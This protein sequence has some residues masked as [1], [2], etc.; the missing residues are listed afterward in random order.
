MSGANV[1]MSCFLAPA[2]VQSSDDQCTVCA[3]LAMESSSGTL[4]T[5][6]RHVVVETLRIFSF[7]SNV[8]PWSRLDVVG[9]VD[10]M[11]GVTLI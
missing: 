1:R 11:T 7:T 3:A 9:D 4:P 10:E 2:G 6:R 5:S 8:P